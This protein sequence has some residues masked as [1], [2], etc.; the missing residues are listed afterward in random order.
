M[1]VV[2]GPGDETVPVEYAV[3]AAERY[4]R[5]ELVLIHGDTH[6]YDFHLEQVTDAVRTWLL[7]RAAR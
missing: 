7:R 3:R 2:H 6:C 5:G 1:L 4:R